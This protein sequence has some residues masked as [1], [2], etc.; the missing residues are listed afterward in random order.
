MIHRVVLSNREVL[1][2]K[3]GLDCLYLGT[4]TIAC[5]NVIESYICMIHKLGVTVMPNSGYA[6]EQL[7]R[8]LK[9]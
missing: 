9:D 8:G 7:T 4:E 1:L 3:E 2:I 6:P 5:P